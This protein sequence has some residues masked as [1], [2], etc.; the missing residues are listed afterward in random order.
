MLPILE[1]QYGKNSPVEVSILTKDAKVLRGLGRDS[2]ADA[3]EKRVAAIR[4]ATM[5]PN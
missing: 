4:A 2:D 1:K 5:T 3:M